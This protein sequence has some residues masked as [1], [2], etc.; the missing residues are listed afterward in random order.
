MSIEEIT[1]DKN[2][3]R[4]T[5]L[6]LSLTTQIR[7]DDLLFALSSI[8]ED[9]FLKYDSEWL[10]QWMLAADKCAKSGDP[11]ALLEMMAEATAIG[12]MIAVLEDDPGFKSTLH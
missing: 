10:E 8:L 6:T 4:I 2:L 5:W 7:E 3:M 12:R 9:Y 1:K 11:S